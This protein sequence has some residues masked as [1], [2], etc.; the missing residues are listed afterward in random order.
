MSNSSWCSYVLHLLSIWLFF[1]F[2]SIFKL[3][4][5]IDYC[6][7]VD[8][9]TVY[10]VC[11]HKIYCCWLNVL[12]NTV[13]AEC[14]VFCNNMVKLCS[15][16]LYIICRSPLF[17]NKGIVFCQCGVRIN[18]EVIISLSFYQIFHIYAHR[19]KHKLTQHIISHFQIN[20]G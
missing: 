19:Q 17:V 20:L 15:D 10:N 13:I 6:H 3:I 11:V 2:I 18:T 16:T 4:P 5:Y 14:S 12:T 9:W 7:I 8:K 1:T